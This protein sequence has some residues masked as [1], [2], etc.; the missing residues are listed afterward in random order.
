[1]T[2][3]RVKRELLIILKIGIAFSLLSFGLGLTAVIFSSYFSGI[4]MIVTGIV[5]VLICYLVNKEISTGKMAT[6]RGL[7]RTIIGPL[8]GGG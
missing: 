7:F 1:M 6:W 2:E 4:S 5:V 8:S 3:Q